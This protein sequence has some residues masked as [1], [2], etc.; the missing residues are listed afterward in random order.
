MPPAK[1]ALVLQHFH[2]TLTAHN[3][4]EL[5]KSLPSVASINSMTVKDY[6]QELSDEGKIRV[7]KIGSG[8]W[9]WSFISEEK[10]A[11]ESILNGLKAEKKKVSKTL[12]EIEEKIEK[13]G[14]NREEE[15][16]S[17][18]GQD[19]LG[20][21][22][23]QVATKK[24][25]DALKT[26]LASYSDNDPTE[27]LRKKEATKSLGESVARWTDN[28]QAL[29]GWILENTGGDREGLESLR[30]EYYGKEYVEGEGLADF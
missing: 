23:V 25:L 4:K 7:E 20:L 2:K 17:E 3:I 1:L 14:V 28:I 27:V 21:T 13:E 16:G 30:R 11:K 6:L 9:Y 22:K 15:E 8:N 18:D 12:A 19:R 5:E 26:E 24:Q 29:E 10:K